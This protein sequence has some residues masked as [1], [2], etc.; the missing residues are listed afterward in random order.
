MSTTAQSVEFGWFIPTNGD[1]RYIGTLLERKPSQEYFIQV[2]QAAEKAG[3]EFTLIPAGGDCWDGWIVGS[4]VAAHTTKLKPLIAMR[5][6]LISPVLAARMA[7]TL[8]QMS[9]GRA[10]I[11]VV[12]GHYPQDLKATGDPL[13][14]SHDERYERTKEFLDVVKGVWGEDGS[15]AGFDY[16]GKHYSVEG[17]VSK[18]AP[19]QNP[20]PPLYFG[21]S[22]VSGKKVAAESADVYLM[23]AEPLEWIQGQIAEME[24]HLAELKDNTGVER[25]LRYGIRAQLVVRE[26][27]EEA[28]AAAW[29][30]L[31]KVEPDQLK[32]QEKLHAKTDATNQK[33]QMD[34]YE[35][36]KEQDYIIGPNLWS[37]L[38]AVRGGG[39]VAF[40]GT[41][42]QVS[43][44][45]LEFVDAG[46]SS[47]ILSGYPHLE[48]AEISGRLLM[49]LVKKKLADRSITVSV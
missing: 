27:E 40:V 49:P 33:R 17:G 11:N 35:Q 6:G 36:S 45:L 9:G 46:V 22:S 26:T 15:G 38:S 34:L 32:N 8:D 29:N 37:G 48:E 20:H 19:V 39:A 42:E 2:A 41:P 47:F 3:Y 23:W 10:L 44:R 43:D 12:T 21:G 14:G 1:G 28:W 7:S 13:H 18:P 31:S 30:I 24:Q 16:E 5:P 25:T 4:W